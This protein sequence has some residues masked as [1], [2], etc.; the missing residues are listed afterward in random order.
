MKSKSKNINKIWAVLAA[1]WLGLILAACGDNSNS[2]AAATS[3]SASSPAANLSAASPAPSARSLLSPDSMPTFTPATTLPNGVVPTATAVAVS[4]N[5]T[6]LLNSGSTECGKIPYYVAPKLNAS[7]KPIGPVYTAIGASDTVGTGSTMPRTDS[8]VAQLYNL[9]PKNYQFVRLGIGG[10]TL[11]E[12]NQC[13]MPRAIA[14]NPT[15]VSDWNAVNDIVRGVSLD[16]YKSDLDYFLQ[17]LTSQTNAKILVGNVPNLKTLP[18]VDKTMGSHFDLNALTTDWNNMI[19]QETAKYPGRV[20]VV[21]V[22]ADPQTFKQHPEWLSG[23]GLHPT[24]SG[25]TQL[26]QAFWDVIKANKLVQ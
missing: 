12:A 14:S 11:H 21:N 18:F 22:Q 6:S 20:W 4:G 23:D 25:Y 13:F 8:W 17:Q 24:A 15:I 26:A 2:K 3:A 10:L 1:L 16:N 19:A 7:G 9:L 5:N